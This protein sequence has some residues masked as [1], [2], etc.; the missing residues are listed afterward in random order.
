MDVSEDKHL[1]G[2]EVKNSCPKRLM[3][4]VVPE[5]SAPKDFLRESGNA[6]RKAVRG[7]V[8]GG[9]SRDER[10]E[11]VSG[12]RPRHAFLRREGAAQIISAC[13]GI[14]ERQ[15]HTRVRFRSQAAKKV[16]NCDNRR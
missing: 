4:A 6:R 15:I 1:K 2:L 8:S 5:N 16:V 13:Q 12:D 11:R 3:A 9:G 14:V 7:R 10:A